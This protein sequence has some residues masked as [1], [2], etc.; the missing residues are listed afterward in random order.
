LQEFKNQFE[1]SDN[2]CEFLANFWIFHKTTENGFFKT[3]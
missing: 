2:F 3:A 1:M